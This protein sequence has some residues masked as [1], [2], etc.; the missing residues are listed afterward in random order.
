MTDGRSSLDPAEAAVGAEGAYSLHDDL[1]FAGAMASLRR[2]IA[3]WVEASDA[4]LHPLLRWQLCGASKYFRP[5][6]VFSCY[7]AMTDAEIGPAVIR[8]A[9]LVELIHNV[10][11]IIDDIVDR[12]SQRRG[13][14]T[15]HTRFGELPALMAS[16][17]IVADGFRL[18]SD[19]RQ[20]IGLIAE[21]MKR[22]GVAECL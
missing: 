9:L 11:L 22:L 5:L 12:S 16:G 3:R 15:L 6:T 21:L 10:S 20:A 8:S 17:Y 2:E 4:E 13:K 19:D 14:P 1:G 18:A 7:R